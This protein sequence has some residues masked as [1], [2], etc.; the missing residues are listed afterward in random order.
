MAESKI[1][2]RAE[3]YAQW[4]QDVI[5]QAELAEA[6][7]HVDDLLYHLRVVLDH[8]EDFILQIV[9]STVGLGR[10]RRRSQQCSHGEQGKRTMTERAHTD[11][12][13]LRVGQGGSRE[14]AW[15]SRTRQVRPSPT[16]RSLV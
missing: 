10:S 9:E 12:P 15:L 2:P 14:D 4:Y 8:V 7:Q 13:E 6:E 5:A 3:D 11:S 16:S 1:P